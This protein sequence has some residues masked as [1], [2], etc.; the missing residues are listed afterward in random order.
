MGPAAQPNE[1]G[2]AVMPEMAMNMNMAFTQT[3]GHPDEEGRVVAQ[4]TWE[5]GSATMTAGDKTATPIGDFSPFLGRQMTAIYDRQGKLVDLQPPPEMAASLEP[6]KQMLT[7]VFTGLPV[8]ALAVGE[9]ATVPV[10]FGLPAAGAAGAPVMNGKTTFTLR[11][12]R[13]EGSDRIAHFDQAIELS[14]EMKNKLPDL[15]GT[16]ASTAI[17]FQMTGAGTMDYNVDR[18]VIALNEMHGTM[19]VKTRFD[20]AQ[21]QGL[22]SFGMHGTIKMTLAASY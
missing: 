22:P 5:E 9:T 6:I 10:S 20:G 4:I 1:P 21:P 11:S 2:P 8:V 16:P 13:F 15:G 3:T 17:V 19:D 7:S 12:I 14:S 18:G